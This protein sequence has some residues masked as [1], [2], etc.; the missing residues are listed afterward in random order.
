MSV[1][2]RNETKRQEEEEDAMELAG[3]RSKEGGENSLGNGGLGLK[4]VV[5]SC[6]DINGN[7]IWFFNTQ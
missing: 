1:C 6:I 3:K 2:G 5:S 4:N 7:S